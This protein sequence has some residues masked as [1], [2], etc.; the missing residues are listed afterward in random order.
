LE[1]RQ[2]YAISQ[3]AD[4]LSVTASWLRFGERLGAL[5]MARRLPN[6]YRLYT[7]EDIE[8]LRR[9]GVGERKRRLECVDE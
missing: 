2:T 5:P 7:D 3:A 6:G 9:L 4:E 1:E 8:R